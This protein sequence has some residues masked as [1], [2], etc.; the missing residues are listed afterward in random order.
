MRKALAALLGLVCSA[1][2][3]QEPPLKISQMQP[4]G[5]IYS[6]D[7]IPL[8]QILAEVPT[9]TSCTTTYCNTTTTPTALAAWMLANPPSFAAD[10][11]WCNNANTSAPPIQC[12]VTQMITML[13][14]ASPSLVAGTNVTI[15]GDWPDQ[16]INVPN[17]PFSDL[18]GSLACAQMPALTGDTTSSAG[19]C[20]T[21]VVD[22]N[23][24][25]VPASKIALASNSAHQ[26]IAATLPW[27]IGDGGTGATTLAGAGI[28]TFT[29]STVEG[30]CAEWSNTTGTAE[31]AGAP[32]G[33]GSG[34]GGPLVITTENANYTT[35]LV[36]VQTMLMH[37]DSSSYTWTIAAH[38]SV[39]WPNGTWI[40]FFNAGTANITI[41]INTDTLNLSPSGTGSRTLSP[42][43]LATAIYYASG[44]WT[45]GGTALQ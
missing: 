21:T 41:A 23:G 37:T 31:D 34:S 30:D 6:E 27:A 16:T 39:V 40:Q 38:A 25:A 17:L 7:L 42:G 15:T 10:T 29:G 24:A 44:E 18:T 35:R 14:G 19:S 45:I 32:C 36:D 4:A 11:T 8:A 22:I 5:A 9:P 13:L 33:T 2:L 28:S 1:A 43:G 20:A 3:A 12:T 26:I